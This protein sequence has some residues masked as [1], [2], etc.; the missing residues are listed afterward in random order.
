ME[1]LIDVFDEN[2]N[3]LNYS[4]SRTKIHEENLWHHHVSVWI[5][6]E[7]GEILLQQRSF[8]KKKNPGM[9][10]KTGGHVD[11][12]EKPLDAAKREVF[13][14]VGLKADN[15]KEL[16]LFK[17]KNPNEHY[18]TYGYIVFTNLK[19][20]EFVIQREEVEQVKYYKIE[21]IEEQVNN[22]NQLFSFTK[23]DRDDFKGQMDMLKKI[24]E[25]ILK[26]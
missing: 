21:E 15:I 4:L 10:S 1:E 19:E 24:R 22:N 13:E 11:A 20:N 2:N 18:Y 6:N 14:E 5:M 26:G 7:K 16:E 8:N 23:W 3:S 17:S 25:E 12:G 9:Y